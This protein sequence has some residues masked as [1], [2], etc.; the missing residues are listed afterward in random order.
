[1]TKKFTLAEYGY[2]LTLGKYAT[3]A[4]GSAW[5]KQ[6]DTIV[7]ATACVKKSD[8]FPGFL[9]LSVEYRELFSAA[10]RIP[11]GYFKREGKPT[12]DE[13]LTSRLIDRS[14][15][16][17][18][19]H[20]YF[21]H[22]QVVANVYSVDKTALPGILAFNAA[23]IALALSSAPFLGPVAACQA[24]RVNGEWIYYPT[25]EQLQASD[26]RIIVAG[27]AAGVNMV[28]GSLHDVTEE[29][30]LDIM[31]TAHGHIK[32]IVAW[33]ES[34][35]AEVG[36]EK[37]ADT[38]LLDGLTFWQE[39]ALAFIGKHSLDGIFTSDKHARSQARHDLEAAF[40]AEV[41]YSELDK[42]A[43]SMAQYAFD[44]VLKEELTEKIFEKNQRVDGRGFTEVRDIRSEVALLPATHGSAL[45]TR[46]GT[47]VLATV[48]LG[49]GQDEMRIDALMGERDARFMLHYNFPPF[50]VGEVRPMRGPGR[51]EVGHGFLAAAALQQVL[52]SQEA[53]GYII[54]IVADV[55]SSDGSSS[56]GTVCS[57]MLALMDA[58]VPVRAMVSG[59][60]MGML[61]NKKGDVRVITDLTGFEDAF[62]Y[63][64][65]KVAGTKDGITAIQMDS[66][67]KDGID[68]SV[69]YDA[70]KQARDGR[71]HILNEMSKVLAAPKA[72]VS[73]LVPRI[74]SFKV[75]KDKI[76]AIIGTGGKVIK[77]IIEVTDTKIDIEDSGM[78][79]IFGHPGE[80][81]DKAVNW[82]KTLAGL[83]ERDSIYHGIIKRRAEFGLFVEIVPGQ[84]GLVHISTVPKNEQQAFFKKYADGDLV[85]VKVLD[86]DSES[87]KIRLKIIDN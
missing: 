56:M 52:P 31:T 22:V 71:L 9:P 69:L 43:Q 24:V 72:E 45:F 87:G 19:P 26:S 16:P 58:G 84:Q 44:Y 27:N 20:G 11:G 80:K 67:L 61:V 23:S 28:E 62:G 46:G 79:N 5:L 66:K 64:D 82:V 21:D 1:M 39:K 68:V 12:D 10:G 77:E 13:V 30:F 25:H 63:M 54:R 55:L 47:Q 38:K 73:S 49:G 35:I 8:E 53:F 85:T 59:V 6:N 51:R 40:Q 50:S 2:E 15:R 81:L 4:D 42:G 78:V 65:F 17:L 70:L 14:I 57:S 34:I 37:V 86:Y 29:Q 3:L 83:I 74:V 48:T 41:G 33:Q 36:V 75:P 32:K 60:A 18:F 7:L 76:G